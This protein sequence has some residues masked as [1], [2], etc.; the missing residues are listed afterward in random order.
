M[1]IKPI[2]FK[3][4]AMVTVISLLLCWAG[5]ALAVAINKPVR[6]FVIGLI[7]GIITSIIIGGAAI[8]VALLSDG[9]EDED[10]E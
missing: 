4:K 9:N 7:S 2:L 1:K 5:Y 10:G 3:I 6:A 8:I